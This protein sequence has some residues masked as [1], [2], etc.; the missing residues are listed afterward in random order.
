MLKNIENLKKC[1]ENFTYVYCKEENHY[2]GGVEHMD[3]LIKLPF[4]YDFDSALIRLSNDPVNAVNIQGRFV[5]I[6]MAEG[7]IVTVRGIGTKEEPLFQ[8]EGMLNDLQI[9]TVK[10]IFHF[11]QSL[12][13]VQ[14][15]FQQ[16]DL[17]PIFNKYEGMPLVRSFSLYGRLMKGIIHQQLNKAFANTLTMRF[18]E[19]YG[20][21]VEGVWTYPSP[22]VVAQLQVAELRNMQF[23][24]RKAE[25][26]IGL[27]KAIAEGG[28]N[29]EELRQLDEE[30]IVRILT[31]YRGIGPWTAQNFL[32][33][34]LGKPNLFPVADVGLQ[35]ALKKLWGM[36]RK[37]TKLEI[38]ER[39]SDWSPYMSYA[40]LYL[41]KSIE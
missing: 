5:R 26:V 28:L 25:Y 24:E 27:S 21:Q 33:F 8:L 37:P 39:F 13:D 17:A 11:D 31:N 40:A 9:N 34:G 38:T 20:Q 14:K 15:H 22:E 12:D 32:L 29:L 23:S 4:I 18:V 19:I 41:W 35:N 10:T 7:N 36:D 16:T 1:L 30:E 2:N 6:P 3:T